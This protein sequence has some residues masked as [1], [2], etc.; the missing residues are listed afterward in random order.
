MK[1]FG[2]TDKRTALVGKNILATLLIKG[3]G[4][5][6][7][8]LLV[9]VTLNCLTQYEY[10]IW[11]TVS[12]MLL[13]ID[14]MDIGLGNGLRNR[15]AEALAVEDYSRAKRLVSTTLAMLFAIVTP[16]I[17]LICV[18]ISNSDCHSL[19]N[20]DPRL[21]PNLSEIL[22]VS[23][24]MM[25]MTFIFKFIGNIYLALQLPAVN[26]ALVVAGQTLSFTGIWLLSMMADLSLMD[27]SL[28]YTIS[29]LVVY[30][31]AYPI[32]FTRYSYMK[33]S[34]SAFTG[35]EIRPLFSLGI[36]FFIAQAAGMVVFTTSNIIISKIFSPDMVTPYQICFRYMGITNILFTVISAPLWSATTNAYTLGDMQWIE[37]TIRRMRFILLAFALCLAIMVLVSGFVYRIWVGDVNIPISMSISMAVC[38]FVLIYGT[39]YSNM[40]CG[41]GRVRMIAAVTTIEAVIYI[42]LAVF[43]GHQM[44]IIGVVIALIGVN[45]ISAV[46]NHIQFRMVV[47]GKAKGLWNK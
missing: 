29:P 13:W 19:L 30:L 9:P 38:F 34:P 22:M 12:S 40:L 1:L 24:A 25:G 39:C 42:P 17:T 45:T 21:V 28:L 3:W 44:G 7:Q 23:F 37:K 5:L 10:G 2:N 41:M 11:L 4:G 32:T 35:S 43:L 6:V 47:S 33:P 27:I 36:T 31:L 26:N 8:L 46:T 20:V 16:I 15:L 18:A 14:S